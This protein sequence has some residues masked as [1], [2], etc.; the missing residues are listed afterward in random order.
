MS[1]LTQ[2]DHHQSSDFLL[3][4]WE[5]YRVDRRGEKGNKELWYCGLCG[6][7]Y[8]IWKS[9]KYLMHLTISGDH[10]ISLCRGD[11]LPKYQCN[12][13]ALKEKK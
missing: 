1:S 11:I 13:K 2:D 12:F 8:N 10:R 5:C 3:S 7:K 4:I 6:N 9:T